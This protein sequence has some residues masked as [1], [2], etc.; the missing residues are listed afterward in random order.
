MQKGVE[1]IFLN[2]PLSNEEYAELDEK[3]GKLCYKANW[4]LKHKNYRNNMIDDK[5]DV[6]QELRIKLITAGV[7][8]KRQVYIESSLETAQKHANDALTKAVVD[9]LC[10]LWENRKRHGANRQKFG[11]HQEMILEKIISKVVPKVDRPNKR[12]NLEIDTKFSTYCK[13]IIWNGLKTMGKKI[14]REKSIRGGQV[15]LSEFDYLGG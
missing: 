2:F 4:Q 13:T 7:Y 11:E 3:F 12:A 6:D 5:D 15:S 1:A 9:E 14:T 8:H 10:H